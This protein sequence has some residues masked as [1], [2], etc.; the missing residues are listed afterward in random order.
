MGYYRNNDDLR[1][2]C[3]LEKEGVEYEMNGFVNESIQKE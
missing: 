1:W 2:W 3:C